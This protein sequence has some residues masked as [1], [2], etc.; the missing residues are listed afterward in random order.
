MVEVDGGKIYGTV[1]YFA[2][3]YTLVEELDGKRNYDS[4]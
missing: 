2:A 4:K 1:K 3:R